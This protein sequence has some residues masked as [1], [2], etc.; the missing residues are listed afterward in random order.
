MEARVHGLHIQWVE[1]DIT[2]AR[3][4]I[5]FETHRVSPAVEVEASTALA[6][7]GT[8]PRE[9]SLLGRVN[10][11]LDRSGAFRSYW[12][13]SRTMRA[14]R[15]AKTQVLASSDLSP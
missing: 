12:S 6:M 11:A 1:E 15:I 4:S 9:A 13:Q 5:C 7:E 2:L 3:P 8:S 10:Q 14:R